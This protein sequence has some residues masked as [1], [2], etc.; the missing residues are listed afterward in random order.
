MT[1]K[2]RLLITINLWSL[3]GQPSPEAEWSIEEK[4]AAV[5]DA[6][7]PAISTRAT[8]APN[9]KELLQTYGLR[10]GGFFDAADPAHYAEKIRACLAVD[11]GPIN[12]QLAD[13]DTPTDE[14][15][16]MTIALMEEAERQQANVYLEVHRDTCTETPEKTDAIAEQFTARTGKP[17]PINFDY[18]HP[19][20]VKHL[21]PGNYVE[22][23][24]TRPELLQF[25]NLW[26]FR[27]FNGH[28]C[29]IPVT[30]GNGEWSPEYRQLRP[31]VYQAFRTW[32][33]G[34]R[35]HEEFWVVPELGPLGGYG[36]SC[37]PNIWEDCIALGN[38]LI[39]IWDEVVAENR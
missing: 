31:F 5:R 33:A 28:H 37:F 2:P 19:A 36:L 7:F 38:D 8:A 6:G 10:F 39:A 27:P 34:N 23:L 20:I 30:D 9:L 24:I 21:H 3:A 12:C 22:R 13:H 32:L 14:A 1:S 29:Q 17:L 26:H 11:N 25:S 35:H 16:E 4:L 15:V 18:S